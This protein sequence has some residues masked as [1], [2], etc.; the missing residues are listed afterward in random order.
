VKKHVTASGIPGVG[1][2]PHDFHMC[3]FYPTRKELLEALL[4]YFA[5]G[6]SNNERC[7]WITAPSI[8]AAEIRE[9]F[10]KFP[11]LARA[12]ESGQLTLSDALEWYGE[13]ETINID[14]MIE[15]WINEEERAL[16]DGYQALRIAGN[17]SFMPRE[18]WSHLMAYE[19]KFH[20]RARGRRIL[21]C[22]S[23]PSQTCLPIDIL[24][25]ARRHDAVLD[26]ADQ[27]WQVFLQRQN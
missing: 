3:H 23:Y 25:V 19:K 5:A 8:P 15:R 4:P 17:A 7:I 21:T 13:P 2:V 18:N 16:E 11:E 27:H 1:L 6:A 20:D 9:N 12:E 26:H 10:A 24:E 22:C 14:D